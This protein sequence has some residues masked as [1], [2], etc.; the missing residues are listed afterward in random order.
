MLQSR[1][2]RK[3]L[4]LDRP[5]AERPEA[6][7]EAEIRD[8]YRWN[9]AANLLDGLAFWFGLAFVSSST[10]VPL[11][12]SKITLNPLII[13]LVAMVAQAGWYL[14]QL[15]ASG[16]TERLDRKKPM[17]V[18]VGLFLERVPVWLWPLAAWL[19]ADR[20]YWALTIFI[21]AY[22]WHHLGA[23]LIAPAWQELLA[24]CFVVNQRG[25]L[26][27]FTTFAGTGAAT[28]GAGFSSW[29]LQ[30]YAFP[31]NFVF[32]FAIAAVAITLSWFFIAL[33]REP[34]QAASPA[35]RQPEPIH[36]KMRTILGAD[37]N[38]RAYLVARVFLVL[39]TMGTGFVTVSAVERW[40]VPDSTVGIYTA[41]LLLG[42]T[43]G[44]LSAGIIADRVG[45]KVPLVMG[46]VA[47]VTGFAIAWLS[48]VSTGMYA[49]FA[50]L[51]FAVGVN[52][53]SGILIALEFSEPVRRPTYAGIANTT[54]G[55][56]GAIAPLLGGWIAQQ[57]YGWLFATSTFV[58]IAAVV[59]LTLT[60][61]DPRRLARRTV[62][63]APGTA[64]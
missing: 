29:L 31:T 42:Q 48:P 49:V 28:L 21:G 54:V 18:N 34:L 41:V 25:R 36:R 62:T 11:F 2:M 32:L 37:A 26:F 19:A 50:L 8:N 1:V 47:Q 6:E 57:S 33:V 23:G 40:S 20:P 13:G 3:L 63:P 60:V 12:V 22:I 15:L 59:L 14:P 64:P 43:L 52:I 35:A 51:G 58:G 38:F 16:L 4:L 9:F 17:V 27:G 10:I 7:I 44:N 39:T 5:V 24:R 45:N 30:R 53:V 61:T 55:I 56:T 46:G